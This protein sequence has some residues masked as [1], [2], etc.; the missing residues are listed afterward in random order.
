MTNNQKYIFWDKDGTLGSFGPF[1][2]LVRHGIPE[3]LLNLQKRGYSNIITTGDN[4]KSTRRDLKNSGLESFF[5]H[6]FCG[7]EVYDNPD[8][9]ETN[10]LYDKNY[11]RVVSA[12]GIDDKQARE[13]AIIIG[14]TLSDRSSNPLG[15]ILI[16]QPKGHHYDSQVIDKILLKLESQTNETNFP[17][18]FSQLHKEGRFIRKGKRRIEFEGIHLTLDRTFDKYNTCMIN[19]IT[20]RTYK[21]RPY[22]I[23]TGI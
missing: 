18:A 8:D 19:N 3:L 14:D 12:L 6:V 10:H 1:H 21:Q 20:A 2:C 22:L 7:D 15:M 9:P 4:E 13:R 16:Y 11:G 5:S 23:E 17:E